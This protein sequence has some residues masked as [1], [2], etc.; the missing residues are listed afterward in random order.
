MLSYRKHPLN[1][2]WLVLGPTSAA[3]CYILRILR[4]DDFF[5][6][7]GVVHD[8]IGVW[9]EAIE[10]PV[11]DTGSDEGVY[12]A[13]GETVRVDVSA[14]CNH[15][16]HRQPMDGWLGHGTGK[17]SQ[18]FSAFRYAGSAT[19]RSN[20]VVHKTGERGN[21]A[22]E[23]CNHGPPVATKFGRV[24]IHA[25]EV[26]H[27]WHGHLPTSNDVVVGDEDRCHGAQEDGV[28]TEESDELC[29]RFENLPRNES[30][31]T[32]EGG[33]QLAP[34]NVDVPGSKG[35]EVVGSRDRIRGYVDTEGN[36]D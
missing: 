7:L 35:H 15:V 14:N 8:G 5:A 4:R 9:E 17:Y 13:D 30:P 29:G 27:I 3:L 22:D 28:S 18:M 12:V 21:G 10:G 36:N 24:A 25:V 20:D 31:G 16:S 1:K 34:A 32:D 23:E 26:V 33:K 19:A 2:V 11:K 6:R